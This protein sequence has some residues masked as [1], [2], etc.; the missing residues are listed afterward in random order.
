MLEGRKAD[1][2]FNRRFGLEERLQPYTVEKVARSA[3]SDV[4]QVNVHDVE[5]MG[6]ELTGI[7]A[8]WLRY[9]YKL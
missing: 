6:S 1:D 3:N 2:Y 5:P 9:P 8:C 7:C 4:G